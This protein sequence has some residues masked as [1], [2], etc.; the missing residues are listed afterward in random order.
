MRTLTIRNIPDDVYTALQALAVRN[1]RS[2]QQQTLLLL[3]H[4]PRLHMPSPI[5]RARNIRTTLQA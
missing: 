1:H 3:K 4:V 2:L 5:E